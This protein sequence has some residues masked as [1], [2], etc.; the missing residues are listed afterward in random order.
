MTPIETTGLI[1]MAAMGLFVWNRLPVVVVAFA[2]AIALWATGI[3]T[4]Q[5]ALAGFGDPAVSFIASLF[6]VSATLES[7]GVTAWIGQRLVGDGGTTSAP[8]LLGL[9]M[10]LV[11]GLT[12]LISANGAVAALLPVAGVAALRLGIP[13]SKLL[14]PLAFAAHAGSNLVL[15]GSPKNV[16]VAEALVDHGNRGFGYFEFLFVGVPLVAGTLAIVLR[17]GDR[18]LPD[19]PSRTIPA[20]FSQHARVLVE[21]YGLAAGHHRLSLRKSSPLIGL[22][23]SPALLPQ[24]TPVQLVAVLDGTT[25]QPMART[26]AAGDIVLLNGE[27]DSV[28]ALAE[29]LHLAFR[30]TGDQGG[31][32]T[33]LN[34]TTGLAEIIIPPRSALI[35]RMVFPGMINRSGDLVILAIQRNGAEVAEGETALE[36]GDTLLLKGTWK[37]LDQRLGTP[38]ILLVNAPDL[39]RRQ[40]APLGAGARKAVAVLAGMV[41]LLATGAVPPVIA[42]LTAAGLLILTGVT[43]VD[44]AF[45]AVNWTTVILV[46]AMMPLST[47][48]D[49]T[50]AAAALAAALVEVV[51]PLGPLGLLTGLFLLTAT[52]GQIMSNT[53]TTL[54][55][56]PVALASAVG[57]GVSPHPVM[58]CICVAGAASFMTPIATAT[59]LM[60]MGP[61]GY[62]FGDYW[63]LGLPLM[64]LYFVVAVFLV[65]MIWPF[66][67]GGTLPVLGR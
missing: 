22:A 31:A 51:R 52:L 55:V 23:P 45:K 42:G 50:G 60:V 53:A 30:E 46:G 14:L 67:A 17:F 61:G 19:R 3:L 27:P 12:A 24:G 62:R 44:A 4:L 15:T 6:I 16:L 18:L 38:D 63:R 64:G 65:P 2:T 20:D 48:M 39:V 54:I 56:I 40:A 26:M 41:L 7:T 29:Q 9:L 5:Q 43:T 8:R 32:E 33:L 21:Q 35:G 49:A 47:A 34:C 59:N 1:V 66:E 36:V 13:P 57:M 28:A 37:A 58:M 25:A 10:L 11:A